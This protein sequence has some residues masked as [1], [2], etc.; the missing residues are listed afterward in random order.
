MSKEKL[1]VLIKKYN[2]TLWKVIVAVL[3]L[4]LVIVRFLIQSKVTIK[5]IEYIF[6]FYADFLMVNVKALLS[7]FGYK[8]T[9]SFSTH[10]IIGTIE[11]L[12]VD[13]FSFH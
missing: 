12:K 9:F 7:I 3:I 13:R 6:G 2:I 5:P 1:S 11:T 10:E 4:L 8:V